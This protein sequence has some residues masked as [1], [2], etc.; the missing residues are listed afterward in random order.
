ML[1]TDSYFSGWV[2][3][4]IFLSLDG[5]L[6]ASGGLSFS[7]IQRL[8]RVSALCEL[9]LVIAYKIAVL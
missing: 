6:K 2:H 8:R 4:N 7:A 9:S 3:Q 5:Q 1:S